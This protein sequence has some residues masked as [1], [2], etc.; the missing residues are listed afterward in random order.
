M[1]PSEIS[2]KRHR[3][4]LAIVATVASIGVLSINST[5]Y[6]FADDEQ[7][8]SSDIMDRRQLRQTHANYMPVKEVIRYDRKH[9]AAISENDNGK[10]DRI[11][12]PPWYQDIDYKQSGLCGAAK[13]FFL[14]VTDQPIQRISHLGQRLEQQGFAGTN[15]G[16]GSIQL[17]F[18]SQ[19]RVWDTTFLF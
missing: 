6:F 15:Q 14:S 1:F 7:A 5:A 2:S 9:R 3:A 18:G 8:L 19:T 4:I 10:E 11:V 16:R 17:R 13:C 12:A